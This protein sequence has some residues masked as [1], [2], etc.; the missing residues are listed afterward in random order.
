LLLISLLLISLPLRGPPLIRL[1]MTSI[2]IG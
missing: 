2:F 1:S